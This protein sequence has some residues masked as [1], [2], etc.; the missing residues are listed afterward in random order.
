MR[1]SL[2][3]YPS[4]SDC[5]YQLA[6][7]YVF[8]RLLRDTRHLQSKTATHWITWLG[9][10]FGLGVVAFVVAEAVPFFGTLIGLL[11]AIAYAPMAVSLSSSAQYRGS[12]QIIVPMHLWLWDF[13]RYRKGS[14]WQKTQWAFHL[15]MLLVGGFMTVG[16]AYAII[17]TIIDQYATGAVGSAFSC[18][19]K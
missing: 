4:C 17:Q 15:V 12:S 16:G 5:L 14:M 10:T 19:N 13:A 2:S 9:A 11:G 6:A 7:K 3:L 18:A 8:V 1:C